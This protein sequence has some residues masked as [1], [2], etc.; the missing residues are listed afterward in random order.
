VEFAAELEASLREFASAGAAELC[1]N[2]ARLAP[3]S[4]LSWEVRGSGEKPLL[5]I[6]SE[7]Y[8]LTR[9]VLA[10]TDHSDTRL[11]LAV[12]RFGRA[13]PDRLEFVRMDFER[14]ARQLAREDY[15][16]HLKEL[17]AVCF[18]DEIVESLTISADLEHSFSANY[19]RGL[20]KRGSS[21]IA[22]L[23][24]PDGESP[25][26][27][28][29]SLTFA[30]LWLD[31]LRNTVHRGIIATLRLVL[32]KDSCAVVAHRFACLACD[33]TLELYEHDTA[34]GALE[35]ID[36]CRAG[37][38]Q[39]WL[40]PC[41]E[42][43]LLLDRARADLAPIVARD[44]RSITVH[45]C[46]S[47][48]EVF[49][50]YRGLPFA[51]WDEG[52]LFFGC[53]DTRQKLT[54][55]AQP[56]FQRLLDD[57]HVHRHP[58]ATDT[59]HSF[60]RAQPERWLEAIVRADVTRVDAVLNPRF[61]Y[62]QV[63]AGI[64]SEHGIIDVLTITRSGRLAILELKATDH[65]HLPL[66]AADYWLRVRRHLELSEFRAYGY[67][68]GIEIQQAPPL[69]YLVAPALR[70][71]SSTGILLRHLSPQLDVTRVGL[72]ESWRRGMRVVSRH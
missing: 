45:P 17:L 48:R 47:S 39:T 36:P 3:L 61:V 22:L 15:C 46:A 30:L 64:G 23:A 66:Q 37:N 14:P 58:L 42:F 57:L 40:V 56:A 53:S 4:K 5:H 59:R 26:S 29:N 8:N 38:L 65:I 20:L 72:T 21:R 70:F 33:V 55:A 43:E 34:R 49:L 28:N 32:P 7:Q 18:P 31:R 16:S 25:D 44:P 54:P 9:R 68:H 41:R 10:I 35:K 62:T 67:F 69:V 71:H 51:R 19:V 6:W 13:R 1:E 60:Y 2:G 24:V 63:F 27:V 12:E 11:V 52:T 50:R